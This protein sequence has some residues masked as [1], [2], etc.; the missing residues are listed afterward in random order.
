MYM[1][2]MDDLEDL[3]GQEDLEG[4]EREPGR[5]DFPGRQDFPGLPAHI[6]VASEELI[7]FRLPISSVILP[8]LLSRRQYSRIHPETLPVRPVRPM[9]VM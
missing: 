1:L 9:S 8:S 3:E 4:R 6:I 2:N 7:P 5:P